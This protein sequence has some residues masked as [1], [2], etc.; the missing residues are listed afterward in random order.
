MQYCSVHFVCSSARLRRLLS[1]GLFEFSSVL[2]FICKWKRSKFYTFNSMCVSFYRGSCPLI[3]LNLPYRN[4]RA[5]W[6]M[7]VSFLLAPQAKYLHPHAIRDLYAMVFVAQLCIAKIQLEP[8]INLELWKW[9]NVMDI[10][11][12]QQSIGFSWLDRW[13]IAWMD[14][15]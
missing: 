15:R 12:S 13:L 7:N 5:W 3:K 14:R 10:W 9:E 6:P 8:H 4:R 2:M 11:Y 1:S